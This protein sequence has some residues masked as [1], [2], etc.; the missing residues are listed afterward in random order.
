M[1]SLMLPTGAYSLLEEGWYVRLIEVLRRNV[2]RFRG[3]LVFEALDLCI[4]QL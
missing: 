3:G 1:S 2:Q 4:T